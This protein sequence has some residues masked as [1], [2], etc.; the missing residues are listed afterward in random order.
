MK[1]NIWKPVANGHTSVDV[2]CYRRFSGETKSAEFVIDDSER[3]IP[4]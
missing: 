4:P 2:H 1:L 3:M